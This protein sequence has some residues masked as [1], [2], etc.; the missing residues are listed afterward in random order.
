[1]ELRKSRRYR[2]NAPVFCWWK[3]ADETL[4]EACGTTRD[5][6]YRGVSVSAALLPSPG[7]CVQL[8]VYLPSEGLTPRSVHLH[9]EGTVIRVGEIGAGESGFAAEVT[10]HTEGSGL[11]PIRD[12]V[13]VQ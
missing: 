8:D 7:A 4:R 5:I 6:S 3:G 1:M 10:F 9:G 12:S 13:K 2:L 11:V